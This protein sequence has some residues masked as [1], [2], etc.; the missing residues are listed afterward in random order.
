MRSY[1]WYHLPQLESVSG[2]F[3]IGISFGQFQAIGISFEPLESV[4]GSFK[5][6][7][8]VSSHWNQFQVI[9]SSFGQFQAFGSS[10]K[11]EK[12]CQMS[13]ASECAVNGALLV[14][15][16]AA[17]TND[18]PI[19]ATEQVFTRVSPQAVEECH[20]PTLG[21]PKHASKLSFKLS[22]T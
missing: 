1:V 12:C 20:Q 15:D 11:K 2:S 4:S 16:S 6:L 7:E 19:S 3:T 5:Q 14:P 8:S 10:C 21:N 18:N 17:A 13:C 22:G 9:G